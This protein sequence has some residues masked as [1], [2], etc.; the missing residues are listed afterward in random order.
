MRSSLRIANIGADR[1]AAMLVPKDA[2]E[3]EELL[4][5]AVHVARETHCRAHGGR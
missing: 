5:A 3:D 1:I 4:A 2:V